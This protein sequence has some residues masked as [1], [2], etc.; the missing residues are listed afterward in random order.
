MKSAYIRCEGCLYQVIKILTL[1]TV[2]APMDYE[3]LSTTLMFAACETRRCVNVTIVDDI[4]VEPCEMLDVTL[5][6]IPGLN[7]RI[8]LS[9]M[10]AIIEIINDDGK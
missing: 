5:K 6:R 3:A 7:G 8:S 2:V 1:I 4:I 9:S 10:A